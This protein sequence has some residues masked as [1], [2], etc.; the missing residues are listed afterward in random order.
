MNECDQVGLSGGC[1]FDCC[2]FLRGGC[3]IADEMVEDASP[4]D[5][6]LYEEIYGE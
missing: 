2:V 3:D 5:R 4:E 1:G 6:E